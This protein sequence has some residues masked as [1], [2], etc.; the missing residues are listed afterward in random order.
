MNASQTVLIGS[1]ALFAST[2]EALEI[3]DPVQPLQDVFAR[4]DDNQTYT[5]FWNGSQWS[6][7]NSIGNAQ[8]NSRPAAMA[9]WWQVV[10]LI[11][12]FARA[13]SN[14][15]VANRLEGASWFGWTKYRQK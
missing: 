11:E 9:E 3:M 12:L 15:L 8:F 1:F 2:A 14:A 7:W 6:G 4:G 10:D 5:I 13:M